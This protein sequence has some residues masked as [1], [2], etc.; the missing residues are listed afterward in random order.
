MG[1]HSGFIHNARVY[2]STDPFNGDC[3]NARVLN[4]AVADGYLHGMYMAGYFS[5]DFFLK[6]AK[7]IHSVRSVI[8][9]LSTTLE[10]RGFGELYRR[11]KG[12][13][14]PN[15]SAPAYKQLEAFL[16]GYQIGLHH[17]TRPIITVRPITT[18]HSPARPHPA[19]FL[20]GENLRSYVYG[21]LIE[22]ENQFLHTMQVGRD[23]YAENVAVCREDLPPDERD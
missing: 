17:A 12:Y 11:A 14:G 21:E 6:E 18:T 19:M 5:D 8:E 7:L 15:A 22:A 9:S 2:F 16:T 3:A 20:T 10:E 13:A 23:A 1:Q 4:A